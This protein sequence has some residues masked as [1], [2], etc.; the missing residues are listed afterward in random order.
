MESG[1]RR[2]IIAAFSANL[3]IAVAKF[4]GYAFTG[5]ASMLA[6][7]VHSVADTS[8]QG[9]LLF[10]AARARRRPTP[11]HPFGYG[12]E[13]YFWAFVV[14]LVIFTLGSMFALYEGEEKLRNPHELESTEWAI[15]ILAIAIVLEAYSMR[16]AVR[17]SKGV[18]GEQSWWA[19]IRHAKVPELPIVLLEDFGALVGLGF[20]L[21]GIVLAHV[22][23]D[24]RWD[25]AGSLAIGVLLGIIA[26]VL[27]VEMKSLLI[28]ESASPASS[29]AIRQAIESHP[30]V[31]RLIHMRTEHLGP[32][33][34]LVAAK[35]EFATG[36]DAAGVARQ[37][38]EVEDAVRA[39]V[40]SARVIFIEPDVFRGPDDPS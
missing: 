18:R 34:I 29:D 21:V 3:G 35:V 7:A 13:R 31:R 33:E 6:E 32:E 19:F 30:C 23:G 26:L 17:E 5:A 8:N 14:A 25:A 27:I 2:A 12:R 4:V 15:G 39:V 36:L 28:G 16:T 20:A 37:I 1:S 9:L 40:P 24:S 10:G 38:D 22:T 11:E